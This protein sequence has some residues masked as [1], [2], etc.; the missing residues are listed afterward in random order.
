M[1]IYVL[2]RRE[3][4]EADY[5]QSN[6]FVVV[7]PDG[8]AARELA[9][10]EQYSNEHQMYVWTSASRTSC[11]KLGTGPGPARVVVHDYLEG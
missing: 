2:K 8:K 11:R 4:F 6:A 3:G 1:N 10:Q 9:A 5:D 7:A